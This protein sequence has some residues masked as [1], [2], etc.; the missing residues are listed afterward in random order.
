ML[1]KDLKCVILAGGYG[2]RLS[3]E[4]HEI[5]KPMVKIGNQPI[6][7]HIMKHFSSYGIKNFI[8]CCGYK[9]DIIKDYFL[10][11]YYL[12]NDFNISLKNNKK[13]YYNNSVEDWNVTIVNT[14]INSLTGTRLKKIKKFLNK[15]E[16]FFFTYGDGV[17]NINLKKL[18]EYHLKRDKISTLSAVKPSGRF[19]VLNISN[20]LVKKFEEKP[21]NSSSLINGGFFVLNYSIFNNLKKNNFSFEY[22]V[23]PDLAKKNNLSAFIHKDFWYA[24]D[25]LRDKNYLNDLWSRNKAPWKIWK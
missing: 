10:N 5:P 3:E 25:T 18:Y 7:W 15:D 6:I 2:S 23:L 1:N 12:S 24:M 19:G 17:S 13:I 21:L 16:N 14:G 4:T 11:Y 20:Y 9:Q 8:I 22:D